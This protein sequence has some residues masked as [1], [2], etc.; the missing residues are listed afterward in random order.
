[1]SRSEVGFT[2][3]NKDH[4]IGMPLA[5]LSDLGGS[6]PVTGTNLAQVFARHAVQT[7]NRL[8]VVAGRN[9][10][11]VERSPVVAPVDIEADA[12]AQFALV[13]FATPPFIENVLITRE[14]GFDSQHHGTIAG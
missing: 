8:R 14:D 5:N 7:V 9:Q 6:V 13:N 1:M 12:L 3:Q 4:G 11:F 10:H 2:E